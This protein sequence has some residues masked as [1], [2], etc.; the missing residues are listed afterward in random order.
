VAAGIRL[1]ADGL[2]PFEISDATGFDVA[3]VDLGFPSIR[4]SSSVRPGANGE[5]DRT[6]FFGARSVTLSGTVVPTATLTR[7]QVVDRLRSFLNPKRRPVLYFTLEETGDERRIL[8]VP[9]SSSAPIERPGSA[10]VAAQWRAPDGIQEAAVETLETATATVDVEP[11]RAYPRTYFLTYPASSI[12]GSVVVT[13]P[14]NVAAYPV[15]ELYGPAT[16]P[17]FENITGGGALEFSGL[18]LGARD[19]LEVDVRERTILLN[20]DPSASRYQFLDFASSSWPGLELE[21][22]DNLLRYFPAAYD[23]G[24]EARVRFRGAW[25]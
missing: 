4:S 6:E 22:G 24:A 3:T 11:G 5:D 15:L 9:S 10:K 14:G 16:D 17:R 13:N 25:I 2:D 8:L 19:Y 23:V 21:A 20:G 18:V 1:E 7:Q 12:V